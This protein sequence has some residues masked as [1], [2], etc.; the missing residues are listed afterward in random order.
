MTEEQ[1]QDPID[2][3]RIYRRVMKVRSRHCHRKSLDDVDELAGGVLR[4]DE[5]EI[6]GEHL[7]FLDGEELDRGEAFYGNVVAVDGHAV[8]N[9]AFEACPPYCVLRTL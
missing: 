4:E 5:R 2:D 1:D 3:C 8:E 7:H 9:V 6:L